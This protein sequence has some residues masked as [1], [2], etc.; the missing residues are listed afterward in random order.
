MKGVFH[1]CEN[2]RTKASTLNCLVLYLGGSLRDFIPLQICSLRIPRAP[3]YWAW[4]S[5]KYTFIAMISRSI[6]P[7]WKYLL[8]FH[9]WLKL[10]EKKFCNRRESLITY[11]SDPER[12]KPSLLNYYFLSFFNNISTPYGLFTPFLNVWLQS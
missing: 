12:I 2:S 11:N 7:W 3:A 8:G 10:F 1:I 6:D 5:R 4:N 9:L